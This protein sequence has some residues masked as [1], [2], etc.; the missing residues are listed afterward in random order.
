MVKQMVSSSSS[1]FS[2]GSALVASAFIVAVAV[3][4]VGCS[5]SDES[6]TTVGVNDVARACAITSAWTN[7]V[8]QKCNDCKGAAT[9]PK[10]D[11]SPLTVAGSCNEQQRAVTEEPTCL[12]IA[13]CLSACSPGECNCI[14]RCYVDKAKCRELSSARDGCVTELCDADCR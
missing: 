1:M 3:A 13:S 9:T 14:E 11:C 12:E 4:G 10:C 8:T 7:T 5:S 2:P 6:P